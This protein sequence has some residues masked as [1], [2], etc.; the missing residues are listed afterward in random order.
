MEIVLGTL[1]FGAI[2]GAAS[3]LMTVAGQLQLLG[4]EVTISTQEAGDLARSAEQ[5]G[6]RVAVG[7]GDLPGQCDVLYAQDAASAYLLADRYPGRP[8]AFCMHAGGSEFARWLP[9][10]LPGVVGAVVV[11]HE[12]MAQQ[13]SALAHRERIVRL[14]QPV[15]LTRFEP[16]AQIAESPRRALLLGNYLTGNRRDNVVSAC[17]QAGLEWT[18]LG[19]YA[20]RSSLTPE[21]E[22]N[23]A[24]LVIG[25][26]RAIVEAMACGRAA[27]VYGQLGG[28]GWV[29]P[30]SYP[31]LEAVNF[32]AV[33]DQASLVTPDA[34]AERLSQYRPSMGSANRDLA[35]LHHSAS[36]HTEQLVAVL[37][38]LAPAQPPSD[39][40]LRELARM[41][42]VQWHTES[43]ALGAAHE[44]RLLSSRLQDAETRLWHH[45]HRWYR[46]L[47]RRLRGR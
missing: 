27:F 14:R 43:R 23:Q 33:T 9:P 8:Q 42:R 46:R 7:E 11:L 34:L 17:E 19:R 12:R 1:E 5:R 30:E 22:I 10:Q 37:E 13:A 36:R 44:A 40:P 15:D 31:K 18:E 41:A 39:A 6:L 45:E 32:A 26:G 29:T 38:E 16:R 2:G 21:Q 28:D 4:H 3:Y 47:A 24:D 35:R 25:E 20:E